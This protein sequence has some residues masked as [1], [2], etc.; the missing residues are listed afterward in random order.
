[1]GLDEFL[2]VE[3]SDRITHH[4]SFSMSCGDI[5]E[6]GRG[7]LP[8]LDHAGIL[9]LDVQPLELRESKF[10]L[11]TPTSEWYFVVVA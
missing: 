8:E 9:T 11:C 1:M 2:R 10:P 3:P 6:P 7:L 4:S 5:Y